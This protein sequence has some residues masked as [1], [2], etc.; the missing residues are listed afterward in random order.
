MLLSFEAPFIEKGRRR[1]TRRNIFVVINITH[2]MLNHLLHYR[3]S[4]IITTSQS[5]RCCCCYSHN[6]NYR[7]AKR[8]E[9][10]D[11]RWHSR[12]VELQKI[13]IDEWNQTRRKQMCVKPTSFNDFFETFFRYWH[14][15]WC[16][17]NRVQFHSSEIKFLK[18]SN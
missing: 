18:N 8:R 9:K 15:W 2:V 7:D 3:T 6:I 10:N 12:E 4:R 5:I 14:R 16:W 17:Q 13:V 11:M 1:W